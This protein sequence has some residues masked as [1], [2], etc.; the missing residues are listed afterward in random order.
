MARLVYRPGVG[1]DSEAQQRSGR[2]VLEI[3][4]GTATRR[5]PLPL[6]YGIPEA[7]AREYASRRLGIEV[8]P[9]AA[10]KL[11]RVK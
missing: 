1:E 2:W 10:P 9:A 4:T 3:G 8:E 5:T 6:G 11:R 7:R